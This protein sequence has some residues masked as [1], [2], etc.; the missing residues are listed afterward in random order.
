MRLAGEAAA[1]SV[2][3]SHW[4]SPAGVAFPSNATAWTLVN[5]ELAA[6]FSGPAVLVPCSSSPPQTLYF[7]LYRGAALTPAPYAGD[8]D[9][10]SLALQVEAGGFGAVLGVAAADVAGNAT[11]AAFLQRM[12]GITSRALASFSANVTLLPQTMAVWPRVPTLPPSARG[13]MLAIPASPAFAFAVNGSQ[14]EGQQFEFGDDVQY[15]WEALPRSQHATTL[16]ID[17]FLIDTTPVTNAQYAAFLAASG[18]APVDTHN[19]LRDWSGSATPPAGWDNKPVTWV[20]LADAA[21]FCRFHGKRLPNEWEWQYA[22]QG[23]DGR[24]F[25][26]GSARDASRIPPPL[27]SRVRAAP[28]DVG[29]FPNGASP[30]GLLDALGLVFQWT[31]AFSDAHSAS[32]ILRGSSYYHP[33]SCPW[34]FPNA[35]VPEVNCSHWLPAAKV[36]PWGTLLSHNK[37]MTMAP[38]YDRHGTVGFRCAADVGVNEG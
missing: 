6:N 9:A 2:Y 30:F 10:C 36:A 15:P 34:Y 4:P 5:T 24:Q 17:A 26:W 38:S 21:A 19:F 8:G 12:A 3:A 11:L 1:A 14:I 35:Q 13:G 27:V 20:D 28:M 31:N 7:D 25:P 32:A 16:V 37:L 18:Y 33:P 23:T 29:S 22:A